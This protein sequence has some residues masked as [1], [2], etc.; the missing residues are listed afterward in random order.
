MSGSSIPYHLRQNKAID[1]NLFVDL[2][3]RVA[4]FKNISEYTYVGMGGPYLEDFRHIHAALRIQNMI[5]FEMDAN[6][7]ARQKFNRPISCIDLLHQSSGEFIA[8]FDFPDNYIVW[9]DYTTPSKLGEQ[10]AELE[11]LVS[12][13]PEGSVFKVTLNASASSLGTPNDGSDLQ[14]HRVARAKVVLGSYAPAVISK[15]NVTGNGYPK[16]LM[17]AVEAAAKKGVAGRA[18]AMVQPLAGFS[19]KDGQTMLTFTGVVLNRVDR[20]PFVSSTRLRHWDFS[21][22][23]WQDPVEISVP[24][25]SFKERLS[26]ESML[27]ESDSPTI[28]T[29]MGYYLGE[30]AE[31]AEALLGNFVKY[32][33]KYPWYSRVEV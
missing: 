19:Y 3:S 33:R 7:F 11:T 26:V 31:E 2:L 5:S 6:V 32:Y 27:P 12:K 22:L 25:M 14:A 10:L 18:R 24:E 29:R 30:S 15:D 17:R 4:R 1:R 23:D 13:L 8:N 28:M 20:D 9:L 16:L 21:S